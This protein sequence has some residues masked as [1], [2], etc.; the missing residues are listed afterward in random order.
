MKIFEDEPVENDDFYL[1]IHK[2][3]NLLLNY[4]FI[5]QK[6][7]VRKDQVNHF[8]FI[9]NKTFMF[10]KKIKNDHSLILLLKLVCSLLKLSWVR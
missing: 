9:L 3:W 2:L 8:C 6:K 4:Q 10:S 7:K 1:K 5:K